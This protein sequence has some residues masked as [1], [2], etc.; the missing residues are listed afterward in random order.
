M[1]TLSSL[2][3]S[4]AGVVAY[5]AFAAS[6]AQS[7]GDVATRAL[8]SACGGDTDASTAAGID[9]TVG[10]NNRACAFTASDGSPYVIRANLRVMSLSAASGLQANLTAN[11]TKLEY[12][13]VVVCSQPP[14][15]L[16]A[17][18]KYFVF[19]VTPNFGTDM[20]RLLLDS[21]PHKQRRIVAQ[22]QCFFADLPVLLSDVKAGN[23]LRRR[24][25]HEESFTVCDFDEAYALDCA[26]AREQALFFFVTSYFS[27]T[28]IPA[29]QYGILDTMRNLYY[30]EHFG[31]SSP[32]NARFP[33]GRLVDRLAKHSSLVNGYKNALGMA[34]K[35]TKL[36][37]YFH[38]Y[39]YF[40]LT[41]LLET[42]KAQEKAKADSKPYK[43]TP[44]P[45]EFT[46]VASF[47]NEKARV[48]APRTRM[49]EFKAYL[50]FEGTLFLP[51]AVQHRID[52]AHAAMTF[53]FHIGFALSKSARSACDEYTKDKY[54]E[55]N[56]WHLPPSRDEGWS[57]P[58]VYKQSGISLYSLKRSLERLHSVLTTDSYRRDSHA[59]TGARLYSSYKP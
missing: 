20:T 59:R 51:F 10:G 50:R 46:S 30:G 11:Y 38:D 34:V 17:N 29:V 19:V 21:S 27:G 56:K 12:D 16:R 45:D 54:D 15:P 14:E 37:R 28:A 25:R 36:R 2:M 18:D 39:W 53:I 23:V 49:E 7:F 43:A 13:A 24:V 5:D 35:D 40:L 26:L 47:L 55:K 33:D 4:S 22:L 44:L 9:V 6:L 48:D 57:D 3:R 42:V 8:N 41:Y 58:A 1:S 52:F 32:S 31:P